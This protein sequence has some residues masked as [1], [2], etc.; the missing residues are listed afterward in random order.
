MREREEH[1]LMHRRFTA[2]YMTYT[3]PD[4]Q[5]D[6][7]NEC[8]NRNVPHTTSFTFHRDYLYLDVEMWYEY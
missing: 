4:T 3:Q 7:K 2:V 8:R 6:L 5:H 1:K